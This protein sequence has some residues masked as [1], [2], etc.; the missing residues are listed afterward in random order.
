[1]GII[2][3]I[4]EIKASPEKVWEMLALDRLSEW[5]FF[6]RVEYTTEMSTPEDKYRVG[7]TA[8]GTP[9][10]GELNNCHFEITD[11]LEKEKITYRLWEK[12]YRGISGG[13]LTSILE[14]IKGGTRFTYEFN[15]N[16]IPWVILGKIISPLIM[17]MG[18]RDFDRSLKNLK[19]ILEK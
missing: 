19:K 2:E 10:G 14:P 9:N 18:K 6:E 7:A 5:M 17:R 11:S 12:V 15:L 4:I 13:L 16:E 1:M 3:K 8:H